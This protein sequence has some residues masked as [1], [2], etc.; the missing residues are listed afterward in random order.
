M[1]DSNEELNKDVNFNTLLWLLACLAFFLGGF[2]I[3]WMYCKGF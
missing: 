3:G 2:G 1:K